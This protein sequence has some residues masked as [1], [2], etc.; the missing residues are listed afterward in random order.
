MKKAIV[1]GAGGHAKVIIDILQRNGEYEVVGVVDAART[2]GV[3]GIPFWGTDED[4]TTIY[5]QRKVEYAFVA[6]GN[7]KIREKVTAKAKAAGFQMIN[8]ISKE[9]IISPRV[10]IGEGVAVMPGAVINADAVLKDGSIVNTNAS[11]DHESIVGEYTHVAPGSAV[12]GGVTIG[13]GCL[14]G[15]GCRVIDHLQIGNNTIIG[16]GSTVI[17]D[18]AGNCT[19][20]GIP[21]KIIKK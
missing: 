19:A 10:T 6:L 3:W 20:V 8:T 18:I 15:A 16:A 12:C 5:R 14:L 1:V 9:A 17:K 11:I 13:R 7:N 2:E 21:A 4:L